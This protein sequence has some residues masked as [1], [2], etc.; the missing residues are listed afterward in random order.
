M[1]F[2]SKLIKE[3]VRDQKMFHD[4]VKIAI[5]EIIHILG[6]SIN[7]FS[8]W[9]DKETGN[10]YNKSDLHKIYEKRE[11]WG[12]NNTILLKSEEILFTAENYFNCQS[13]EGMYLEN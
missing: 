8:K 11:R 3:G 5:H 12:K 1:K 6:F 10:L 13:L 7:S 4:I 9:I 2:N